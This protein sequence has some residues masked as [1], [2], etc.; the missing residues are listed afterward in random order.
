MDV[1]YI[2]CKYVLHHMHWALHLTEQNT[3]LHESSE[4]NQYLNE[5]TPKKIENTLRK[6]FP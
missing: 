1:Y 3:S 4:Q 6:P 5:N 2:I